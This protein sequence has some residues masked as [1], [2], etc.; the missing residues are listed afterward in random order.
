M[1]TRNKEKN[2]WCHYKHDPG[3]K[4]NNHEMNHIRGN[5]SRKLHLLDCHHRSYGQSLVQH[6]LSVNGTILK[7]FT[8]VA[9]RWW[10]HHCHNI[11]N[12]YCGAIHP[13]KVPKFSANEKQKQKMK[14]P[15]KTYCLWHTKRK[16]RKILLK[17]WKLADNKHCS[18]NHQ[19]TNG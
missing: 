10:Y 17:M 13:R 7:L 15:Q 8:V 3:S 9:H 11:A 14:F 5:V 6:D 16:R 4:Q 19:Y 18:P 2:R 12:W 1:L